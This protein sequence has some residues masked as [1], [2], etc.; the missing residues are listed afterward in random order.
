MVREERRGGGRGRGRSGG[1]GGGRETAPVLLCP[2]EPIK[3]HIWLKPGL[4][5]KHP[6]AGSAFGA[7]SPAPCSPLRPS[8]DTTRP[9]KLHQVMILS[10]L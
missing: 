6:R 1:K 10:D 3:R 7:F 8:N 4:C 2:V 9:W 5:Q